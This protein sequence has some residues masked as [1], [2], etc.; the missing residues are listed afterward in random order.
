MPKLAEVTCC[1]EN[2]PND[3]AS[4]DTNN[5][6]KN[7]KSFEKRAGGGDFD[8]EINAIISEE[9]E[10]LELKKERLKQKRATKEKTDEDTLLKD[11]KQ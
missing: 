1:E 5:G 3:A 11:K 10:L 8:N 9:Q 7:F 2:T 4:C 6:K